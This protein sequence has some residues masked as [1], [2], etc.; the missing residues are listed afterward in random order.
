MLSFICHKIILNE[1][2]LLACLLLLLS[3]GSASAQELANVAILK[4]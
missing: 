2:T 4:D 3:A 1:K